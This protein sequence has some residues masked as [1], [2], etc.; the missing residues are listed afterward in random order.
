MYRHLLKIGS[1]LVLASPLSTAAQPSDTP[2]NAYVPPICE[3]KPITHSHPSDSLARPVLAETP[4]RPISKGQQLVVFHALSNAIETTY[5]DPDFNGRYWPRVVDPIR[6]RI[7]DGLDTDSFYREMSELVKSLGD[8]HSQFLTPS[9]VTDLNDVRAG[10]TTYVGLG[11]YTRSIASSKMVAISA[12]VPDS[13]AERSGLKMHDRIIAVNGYPLVENGLV[14]LYRTLGPECS[15]AV[16]TVQTPGE[17]P[18]SI[19]IV[20]Y[21]VSSPA[22]IVARL[23][24]A[25]DGSRIGYVFIP[26]FLDETIPDQLKKALEN[27]GEL[28]GLI[29]DNRMNGGGT[30]GVLAG[31]LGFFTSGSVGH[32]VSRSG[33]RPL[34]ILAK[35]VRNSQK[36][37]LIVLIG[38]D[39]ASYA[40]V[41]SGVLQD[42][43]RARI[44]GQTSK[45]NV[46]TLHPHTFAD[47]SRAYLAQERFE[48]IR[49]KVS[50]E[51]RGVKPD[52]EAYAEWDTFTFE[53]DPGVAAAVSLLR[54][55]QR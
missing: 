33:K 52:I 15:S 38:R 46:E 43:G 13:P 41:F 23:L 4:N 30:S 24:P 45:G 50:W 28:D 12:V 47:G 34:E 5:I 32:F 25:T 31:T 51:K 44:V 53:N 11:V 2:K 6:A 7:E 21:R 17:P 3:G 20:R 22:P 48:P 16:F 9:Q 26:S 36:V 14:H 55:V 54:P 35:R 18:R 1:I 8:D 37:P 42:L 49:S 19:S 29:I 40:E 39:T 27:F 10:E